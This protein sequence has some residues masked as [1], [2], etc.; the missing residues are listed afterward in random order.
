MSNA[1]RSMSLLEAYEAALQHDPTFRSAIHENEA[2]QQAEK[3][4]L[5]SLLPNLSMTHVQ[6]KNAGYQ[7]PNP[8]TGVNEF[9]SMNF[10]S[11]VTTLTLR[12]PLINLEAVA[13]YRQGKAQADSSR[14]RF[15]GRSQQL[16]VRLVEAYV[17]TLLAQDHVKIA[18]TQL[19]SLEELKRINERMLQ[20]GEGTTTDVLE[21]QSKHAIAQAHLIETQDNLAVAQLKLETLI[22]QKITKLDRLS[23]LFN[24]R[25]IQLQDYDS[26]YALA[27]DRN[28]EVATQRHLVTSGKEEINKSQ[29]G[30]VPR[31]DLVA[32][33][34]RN[35]S[36]SPII[37][38]REFQL[39]AAGIEVNIPLYSGGRVNA[40]TT[41]ARANHARAEAELD[42][43]RDKVMV[44]LRKQ[45]NLLQ[46]GIKRIESLQLGVKSAEL[47]VSATEKSIRGG[48]RIN[49]NL[50]DAQQQ[51][52]KTRKD[53][54]EARYNHLLAYLRLQLAAGT[55][56]L[57]DLRNVASYFTSR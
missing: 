3:L 40:L 55:L 21:T 51:L 10:E 47:L 32:S 18:E 31:V 9:T 29:A 42:A 15:T 25:A 49:L 22:G 50:L 13:N 24:Y 33:L 48:I 36:G 7:N 6:S 56:V 8:L 54:A 35:L 27:M 4:G 44:E 5:A 41:Q 53:L 1:A 23:D 12:Q 14:A 57:D 20:K 45:Y 28:A 34:S 26:W 2:G 17:E 19:E 11:Q 46:S 38:G 39:G 16:V 52:H 37:A 30:H 43:A